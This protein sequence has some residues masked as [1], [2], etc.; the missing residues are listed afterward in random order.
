[1]LQ[2]SRKPI[3]KSVRISSTTNTAE[4]KFKEAAEALRF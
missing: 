1:M 2:P 4:E 3:E